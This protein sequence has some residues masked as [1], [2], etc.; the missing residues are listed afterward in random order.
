VEPF[1][2][3]EESFPKLLSLNYSGS[4]INEVVS[5][6]SQKQRMK[7]WLKDED[8]QLVIAIL[9]LEKDHEISSPCLFD[10]IT[11]NEATKESWIKI[12]T[13][14][15][16]ERELEFLQLRYRKLVRN[17]KLNKHELLYFSENYS[18]IPLEKF[19]IIFPGKSKHTLSKLIEEF[20]AKEQK[21]KKLNRILA[22]K[23]HSSNKGE[24]VS[25][26]VGSIF[27]A[28]LSSENS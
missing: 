5:E 17:Q 21:E 8:R 13:Q 3:S 6:S 19:I 25:N 28:N 16:T 9:K 22:Q 7:R 23:V 11:K 14:M 20:I 15:N 18:I 24:S 2:Q 10:K 27:Y 4:L 26:L 1:L 12:K